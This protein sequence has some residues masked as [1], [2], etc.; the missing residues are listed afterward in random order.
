M[1]TDMYV[2]WKIQ[3]YVCVQRM[4]NQ[5]CSYFR[6]TKTSFVRESMSVKYNAHREEADAYNA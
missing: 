4:A 2:K 1:T 5:S 3:L 6:L